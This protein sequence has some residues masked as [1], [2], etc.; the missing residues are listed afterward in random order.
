M[1]RLGSAVVLALWCAVPVTAQVVPAPLIAPVVFHWA[2]VQTPYPTLD[3][4]AV[5]D[6]SVRFWRRQTKELESAGFNGQLFQ[7]SFHDEASQRNHLEALRQIR[8]ERVAAGQSLPPRVLPFFAAESFVEYSTPK[9]VLSAAGFE[10]FYQTVRRFFLVYSEYFPPP[11]SGTV[12]LDTSMLATVGGK[13]FVGLWW[14][15][16]ENY[17]L[18]GDFFIKVNDRL[19]RDFGVRAF[20]SAHDHWA[21]GDPDEINYLFNGMAPLQEG[22]HPV[23]RSVDLLV[24]FWPPNLTNYKREYFVARAGGVPYASGWDTLLAASRRP[25]IVLVE[26]YNEISEGSHLMASRPVGHTPGDGHW[27]GD[28]GDPRCAE[29]PCHPAEYTDT[30]GSSNPW[31]YLDLT[32]RKIDDWLRGTAPGADRVAPHARLDA[33]RDGDVVSNAVRLSV[34]AADDVA[35]REVSLYLDEDLVYRTT[36]SFERLLKT[37]ALPNGVHRLR[38]ESVDQAGNRD[39]DVANVVVVNPADGPAS[40]VGAAVGQAA[41]DRSLESS[42]CTRYE[43]VAA[44]VETAAVPFVKFRAVRVACTGRD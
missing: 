21:A 32:R 6:A 13:V 3:G 31:H 29:Q 27:T 16:L 36:G 43:P 25:D 19:E 41:G 20:W 9:D 15:P 39:S 17:R 34:M 40:R 23:Y 1:S 33:P 44:S 35:L 5:G 22:R 30:W 14:V 24:G 11:A 42:D 28:P 8:A 37:W 18:P 26:S 2:Q 12:R 10:Q 7:I 38:V 4:G